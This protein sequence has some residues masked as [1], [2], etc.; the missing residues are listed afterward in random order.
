MSPNFRLSPAVTFASGDAASQAH[1][2]FDPI[3]HLVTFFSYRRNERKE[4]DIC[5]EARR[6]KTQVTGDITTPKP[7]VARV[8]ASLRTQVTLGDNQVTNHLARAA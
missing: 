1:K 2:G 5:K 3:C 4:K 6:G 8:S 7:Y